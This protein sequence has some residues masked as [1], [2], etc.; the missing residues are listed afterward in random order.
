M[1]RESKGKRKW[2]EEE[3]KG[4]GSE[5]KRKWREGKGKWQEVNQSRIIKEN[6]LFALQI[7]K[8]GN[9][10]TLPT[11]RHNIYKEALLLRRNWIGIN[12]SYLR[13]EM[14]NKQSI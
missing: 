14:K 8:F 3:V 10:P 4:R 7:I 12:I 9:L 5:G 2:R 13:K 1:G 6:Y 11:D